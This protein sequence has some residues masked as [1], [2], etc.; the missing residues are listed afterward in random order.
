MTRG[1]D[2]PRAFMHHVPFTAKHVREHS[3]WDFWEYLW[4]IS[5]TFAFRLLAS[6]TDPHQLKDGQKQK[7]A[8]V[9]G[10]VGPGLTE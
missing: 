10:V 3:H 7:Q 9:L 5:I 2:S 8:R 1:G 4:R 6:S